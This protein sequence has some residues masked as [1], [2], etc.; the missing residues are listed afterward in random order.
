MHHAPLTL[1]FDE[2]APLD[3]WQEEALPIGNGSLG[4]S[5]FGH[6][7]HDEVFLNEKTLWTGGPGVPG[8]RY[9]NYPDDEVAGRRRNL[10]TVRD[11]IDAQGSMPAREVAA[12]L[13]QPKVGYGAYQSFGK[14]QF[15]FA[16][17]D[18]PVTGYERALDISRSLGTVTYRAGGVAFT[19]EY[20]ASY[21]HNV[22]MMRFTADHPGQISFRVTYDRKLQGL[23]PHPEHGEVTEALARGGV[24]AE[25][26]RL[27]LQGV[28]GNNGLRYTALAE[29]AAEGGRTSVDG[30]A[31]LVDG[32]DAVTVIWA[33][34]TDYGPRHHEDITRSY[35]NGQTA[36]AVAEGVA[37]RID[38]ALDA[39]WAAVQAAHEADYR[40]LF[41]RVELR[42]DGAPLEEL[43]YQY[44]RYLLISSSRDGVLGAANLQGVWNESNNPPWGAD[45]HTNINIQMNYWPA[46]SANLSETYDAYLEYILSIADGAGEESARNV[47][48]YDDTW[49]VMNETTP[50]G[51]T[52]VFDWAT[53]FWFPDA[54]AWLAQAFWWKYLYTGDE[55]FLREQAYPFL[56]RTA[57]F[58][59]QYLVEDPRD[60]TLVANPSYSP[61][62]GD[63]TSGAAM[64]Q[65]IVVE[66]F[67]TTIEAARVLGFDD[68]AA[69]LE[70]FAERISSGLEISPQTGMLREW[71]HSD[72][73]GE[74]HH[75]HS[76]HLYA[77]WPGR[78]VAPG[79]DLAEA[80][81]RSLEHRGD[82]GTGWS[83]AWKIH[84]WAKLGEGDRAHQMLR[85]L[86]THSTYPNLWDAHPPFQIDGNFGA[87][88]GINEMLVANEPGVV[89]V[90]PAL[91][92][93]WPS[94]SFDGIQA[95]R[96]VTVGATWA[97]GRVQEIRLAT[98]L[99]GPLSVRTPMANG[100]ATVTDDEGNPVPSER[101][102]G[103]LSF[104][105]A[106][107]GRYTITPG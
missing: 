94:G 105:A 28:S 43:F 77:L 57:R 31:I 69:Q 7:S 100:S 91:P 10:R 68:E 5:L 92:E 65:Q 82:G 59:K 35:R 81:R 58:W 67:A 20:L 56:R 64:T 87:T 18:G 96:Q 85:N 13:G 107:G 84:F 1:R 66:L 12:L 74:I 101:N 27:R 106:A 49:M 23:P 73:L 78:T 32:A 25:G 97:E 88:S 70:S 53:A 39:G 19:R 17:P 86:L 54:N 34:A 36:E 37:R 11:T 30:G 16:H 79:T 61:E 4:A 3:R 26:T 33:A 51:F 83:M 50:W 41:G 15:A 72:A 76:S 46:F 95:W 55:A 9:G 99:D 45:Y 98:G 62:H 42:L 48:G 89:V 75:R 80:A 47:F 93:A 6:V 2:P 52:G 63:F 29:V 71:K 8:Y 14:L 22:V 44:G 103:V 24:T 102:D 40:E 38:D 21:P 104:T 90:L 60:G